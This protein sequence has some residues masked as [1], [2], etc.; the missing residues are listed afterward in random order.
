MSVRG[1][2]E[3]LGEQ[4]REAL[5]KQASASA[6]FA[7]VLALGLLDLIGFIGSLFSGK[8][9]SVQGH[10]KTAFYCNFRLDS[11]IEIGAIRRTSL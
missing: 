6:S 8:D 10:W 2:L 5:R 9:C 1:R 7:R 4:R 3:R 11:A